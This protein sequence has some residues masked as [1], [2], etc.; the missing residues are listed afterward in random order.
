VK[1]PPKPH[2]FVNH[3]REEIKEEVEM[4]EKE[5]NF[6]NHKRGA[7]VDPDDVKEIDSRLERL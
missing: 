5:N 6:S 2:S 7:T 4:E 3:N 1:P